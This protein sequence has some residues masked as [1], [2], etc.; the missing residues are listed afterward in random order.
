MNILEYVARMK[1]YTKLYSREAALLSIQNVVVRSSPCKYSH[2]TDLSTPHRIS[3][4][5]NTVNV[6]ASMAQSIHKFHKLIDFIDFHSAESPNEINSIQSIFNSIP[7]EIVKR[8]IETAD[9][10]IR[11]TFKY[12]IESYEYCAG[13]SAH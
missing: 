7:N 9:V 2:R 5:R 6:F 8:P 11:H 4:H 1:N 10:N 12:Y 13:A 3:T